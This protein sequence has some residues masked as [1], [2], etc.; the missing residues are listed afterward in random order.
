ML[1]CFAVGAG[2]CDG[3]IVR[4]C[5][6]GGV[7]V[8][9]GIAIDITGSVVSYGVYGAPAA[10]VGDKHIGVSVVCRLMSRVVMVMLMLSLLLVVV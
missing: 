9:V 5:G 7:G 3:N 10:V 4:G 2:C 6:V 1:S 8:G